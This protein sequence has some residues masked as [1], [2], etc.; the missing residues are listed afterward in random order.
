MQRLLALFALIFF[1][2]SAFAQQPTLDDRAAIEAV[3]TQFAAA[4][5]SKDLPALTALFYDGRIEWRGS[6]PPETRV[7]VSRMAG[8]PQPVVAATGA[9]QFLNDPQFAKI[10]L[11]E[12]FG[13]LSLYGDGQMASATFNYAFFAN[14]QM[15][16]WGLENWQMV[17]TPDGW[18]I[19][20]LF[21][22][23]TLANVSPMPDAHLS[24]PPAAQ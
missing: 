12:D 2:T 11:Q 18:R 13:P 17:K 4:I 21:F 10:S 6:L 8:A 22:T 9:Y 7:E 5:Q 23:A 16:N 24:K 19:L 15:Q 14:G 1:S 3:R 20:S